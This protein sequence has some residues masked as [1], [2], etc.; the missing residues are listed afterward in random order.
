MNKYAKSISKAEIKENQ[1]RS[2]E[3]LH[4][5]EIDLSMYATDIETIGNLGL[6]LEGITTD[7]RDEIQE[8]V[9]AAERVADEVFDRQ[10]DSLVETLKD[11]GEHI[12]EVES[13]AETSKRNL[14]A[15]KETEESIKGEEV[16]DKAKEIE[17]VN[18]SDLE[19]LKDLVE[20]AR[21]E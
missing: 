6:N 10:D 20:K 18:L 9:E 21:E 13:L 8:S 17:R 11:H 4:K 5:K 2:A 12:D 7:A 14:D 3:V 15:I 16:S 1:D 19:A